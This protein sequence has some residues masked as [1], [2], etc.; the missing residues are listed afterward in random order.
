MKTE[1]LLEL[2]L[3]KE[4]ADAV[5][6]LN[7]KDVNKAKGDLEAKVT[8][9]ETANK[10][11]Q[12]LRDTVK[13]FDGVDVEK[14]RSDLTDLQ[15]QYD[16]DISAAKLDSALSM[17][18]VEDKARNPALAKRVLDMSALKLDGDK[19]LGL[20]EQLKK[21][22][23]SDG[24]LFEEERAPGRVQTGLEH[25]TH[26]DGDVDKFVA[27]AMKGAGLKTD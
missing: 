18:L 5:F 10:T 8:E 4:Q 21:L 20:D 9:L 2:G 7:G 11:I 19:L 15:T 17:A 13:K 6:A 22:R 23:E 14:L 12:G 24:Y 16:T 25:K 26:L 1:E 3:T 27:A